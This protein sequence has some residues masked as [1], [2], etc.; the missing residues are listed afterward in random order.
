MNNDIENTKVTKSKLVKFFGIECDVVRQRYS[1]GQLR[2]QLF[3]ADT[4][5]NKAS[6]YQCGHPVATATVNADMDLADDYA[7]IKNYSENEGVLEALTRAGIVSQIE[8]ERQIGYAHA[9]IVRVN[10]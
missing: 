10:I 2:L 8:D 6:G 9:T 5:T 1:D 3:V 7:L 4:D